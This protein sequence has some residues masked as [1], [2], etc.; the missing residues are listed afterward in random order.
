MSKTMT[1]T[2]HIRVE[3]V[4]FK[5]ARQ[6]SEV[7][8]EIAERKGSDQSYAGNVQVP[9][10]LTPESVKSFY[11]EKIAETNDDREKKVYKQTIRWIDDM[12]D[13]KKKLVAL[14]LKYQNADEE[15]PDDI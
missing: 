3:D 8:K 9:V 15:M 7:L 12:L 6:Q 13:T 10:S 11:E 14:E 4:T 5:G 2:G 1:T